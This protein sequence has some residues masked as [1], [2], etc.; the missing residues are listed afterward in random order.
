MDEQFQIGV[1]LMLSAI[2]LRMITDIDILQMIAMAM[3]IS[4]GLLVL[5]KRRK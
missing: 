3:V 1:F 2:Y 5:L 4:G